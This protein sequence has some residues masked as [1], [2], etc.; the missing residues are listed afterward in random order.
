MKPTRPYRALRAV[1]ATA[2]IAVVLGLWARGQLVGEPL[3]AMWDVVILGLLIA[4]GI[5]V[6]GRRTM[7]AALEE[8]Q[9]VTGDGGGS[10]DGG[11]DGDA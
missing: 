4:S 2:V 5:A 8:A 3:G 10:D 11:T 1:V 6:Y 9:D 7:S